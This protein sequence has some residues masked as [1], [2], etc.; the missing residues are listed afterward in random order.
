VARIAI[1]GAGPGGYVAAVRARQL[2]AEVTLIEQEHLG[3]VCLNK[4]CIPSK[5]LLKSAEVVRLA[6]EELADFGVQAE[7]RGVD[8]GVVQK[9]KERVVAQL[10]KGV[11]FLMKGNGVR[12]V[13]GKGRLVEARTI[14]VDT[15]GA[16]EVVTADKIIVATGSSPAILPLPGLQP[17]DVLTSN[18]MLAIDRVPESLV[19]IGGGVIACEFAEVFSAMGAKVTILEMLPRLVPLEDEEVSAEL[20]RVF[21]RR[22]IDVFVEAKVNGA[23]ARDGKRVVQFTH[24]GKEKEVE[25]EV[26][27]S[28]VGRRPNTEGIGLEEVGVE[29]NRRQIVVNRKMETRVPG[30]YAIGDCIGGYLLAHVASAE[31]KVAAAN[32]LGGNV[33]MDYRAIPSAV[34]TH[35]EVGSTGLTETQAREKGFEVKVGRFPFRASG[36]A[37]AEGTRDGFVKL[38][39]DAATDKILGGHIIGHHATDVIH[40]VVLA[41]HTGRTAKEVADMIHGH[42]TL[43]EPIMEAAEDIHGSAVHK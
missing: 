5:A 36:R 41:I 32:A 12:V 10:V 19:I 34:F 9:R 26:A 43:A 35:P 6:R 39:A 37:L 28:A 14:S 13:M 17:P 21:K 40:E 38:I 29:L 3:G 18:E 15:G 11:E 24:G 27:L 7:F 23:V 31:G 1:L 4:G 8:W 20:Q 25:A 30:V 33:E 42:P 22:R 2:G 16:E